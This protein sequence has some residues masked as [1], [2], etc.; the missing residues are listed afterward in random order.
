MLLDCEVDEQVRRIDSPDRIARLKGSD[1]KGYR[2]H[3]FNTRLFQP[4]VEEVVELDTTRVGPRENAERIYE[5][6]LSKGLRRVGA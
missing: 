4:P 1:P 6:L 5:M 2:Q 3:R